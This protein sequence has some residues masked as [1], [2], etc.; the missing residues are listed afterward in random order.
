MRHAKE[1]AEG[2]GREGASTT[3]YDREVER[4]N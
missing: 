4:R 2:K 1:R 3:L